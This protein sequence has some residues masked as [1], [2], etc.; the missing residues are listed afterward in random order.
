MTGTA[1]AM[2]LFAKIIHV[3]KTVILAMLIIVKKE[4]LNK[5]AV[6]KLDTEKRDA[7]LSVIIFQHK[8]HAKNNGKAS[9]AAMIHLIVRENMCLNDFFIIAN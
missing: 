7:S 5:A 2:L 1:R 8:E 6:V 4:L 3:L 9:V